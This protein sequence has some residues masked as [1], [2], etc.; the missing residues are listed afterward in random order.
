MVAVLSGKNPEPMR[1][2]ESKAFHMKVQADWEVN[3]EG[4][5]RTEMTVKK[6]GVGTGRLDVFVSDDGSEGA[7]GSP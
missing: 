1:L 3:A 6:D 5:V 2:R 7:T 4:D